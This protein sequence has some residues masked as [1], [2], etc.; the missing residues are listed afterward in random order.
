MRTTTRPPTSPDDEADAIGWRVTLQRFLKQRAALVAL[1]WLLIL[2]IASLL[3]PWIAPHDPDKTNFADA[4]QNPSI[5]YWLGT[6][7]FGRDTFS[8]VLHAGRVALLAGTQAVVIGLVLGIPVG[9]LVGYL[10]GW[11]DRITMRV[12]DAFM[13]V[14][15]LIV[16]FAIIAVLGPGL[17]NAM[18]AVG[19]LFA[20]RF[21]RL[22]RG[23]TLSVREEPY[24]DAARLSGTPTSL[25]LLRTVLPNAVGPVI[26][27]AA[28]Y[29]GAALLIEAMLS[30]LGVGV[31]PPQATWGTM[32]AD[33]RTEQFNHPFLP[34]PPGLAIAVTVLAFNLLA[35][36]LQDARSG[37]GT[38]P[39]RPWRRAASATATPSSA[40]P[41]KP[42]LLNVTAL[43]AEVVG[44]SDAEPPLPALRD[45][46]LSV[47]RGE[48][49]GLVGESGSG[50]SLTALA[51]MGVLPDGVRATLGSIQLDGQELLGRP[52]A[53][54]RRLR[55]SRM[56]IIYQQ[57][58]AALNPALR[59]GVQ[60]AEVVR[61]HEKAGRHA[62]LSRAVDLLDRVGVPNA[63]ARAQD[64]PHQFSGGMAQRVM[65][66]M[67]LAGG[68]DLLLADEPTTA[69][70]VTNQRRVLDLIEQLVDELNLGVL[71]I[72][73]D[74]GVVEDVCQRAVVMYAGQVVESG[75][76]AA[77]FDDPRHP[78]TASLLASMPSR[79]KDVERLPIIPGRVPTL[80]E[81]GEGCAFAGR[82][83][84]A[85]DVCLTMD[86]PV[87][88]ASDRSARC[89]LVADR[90]T[91]VAP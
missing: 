73:H 44:H 82:C 63:R 37:G 58:H 45:V 50:K 39:D 79:H 68:P 59:V 6:D 15:G 49:V 81:I 20:V 16:A 25:I 56:G 14:P 4:F 35:D 34:V 84:H 31:Q 52:E 91:Q 86:P 21:A 33:A 9:L 61:I 11:W 12:V 72:T 46:T 85:I 74:M 43:R 75:P 47:D 55:G 13:S 42:A 83:A 67:A 24:V 38:P 7:G 19:F 90:P 5:T 51:V 27:Q 40:A 41:P 8:R 18:I 3:A 30:F 60:I 48:I 77:V 29:F 54:L 76:T 28:L 66:A 80:H 70:D 57:P 22:V 87:V 78:Y 26:V 1:V 88:R 64:F 62:A 89:V 32:L 23:V 65:I 36:G 10:G 53:E 2:V 69:L 17:V 71:L